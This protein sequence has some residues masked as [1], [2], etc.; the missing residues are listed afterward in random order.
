MAKDYDDRNRG[1][2]FSERDRKTKDTDR[3][4]SGTLDVEGVQY[5]ISGWIKESKKTGQ[6]F[7]SL[8]IKPKEA[9]SGGG[10]IKR[11][12]DDEIPF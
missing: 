11:D 6:K 5:W 9:N 3:D 4:Y 12:M 10:S 8:S 1:A 2:L 7:L